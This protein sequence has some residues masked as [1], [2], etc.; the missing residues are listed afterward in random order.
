MTAAPPVNFLSSRGGVPAGT[1][2]V[3]LLEG[4]ARDGGLYVPSRWP[5]FVPEDFA[6][7]ASL[8]QVAERLLAPFVAGDAL[9]PELPALVREIGRA[10]V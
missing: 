5:T 6:G 1:F 9:A 4:L 8:A 7:A 3:A 10:H 2:S